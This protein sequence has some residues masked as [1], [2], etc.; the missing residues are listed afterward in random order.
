[1]I[2]KIL[3]GTLVGIGA[4]LPGVSGGMIAA[5]FNIYSELI[6]AL[7]NVTK[8]PIQ[9]IKSI[10][11]YIV[12]IGLGLILGFI[13]VLL[14]FNYVP[15]PSTLL[16]IGLII[17]GVPEIY[18]LAKEK[19]FKASD[20][21]VVGITFIALT[22]FAFISPSTANVSNTNL[23]MWFI[24]GFL[25][26][27]S[28]IIPGLSGT[29]I[30][31]MIG[32]YIPMTELPKD[33]LTSFFN[34]DFEMFMPL[35]WN[36]LFVG[37]GV[38]ATFLLAGKGLNFI[39]KKIPRKFYQF[40]LGIMLASPINI[41]MSLRGEMLSEPGIDIFNLNAFWYMW[42]IGIILLPVGIYIARLFVKDEHETE[43]N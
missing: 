28:L 31:M 42:L 10:W 6:N 3:Q 30:L 12:G 32:Y 29:M 24:V 26:A 1:M 4:I 34:F 16:F 21:I 8:K 33:A 35:F 22:V 18:L 41:I 7:D 11:E 9:A 14:V 2:K 36:G 27:I 15:I 5:A 25:L 20:F 19:Q 17:G 37:L 38:I 43:E 13:L 40:V 23:F 39:L